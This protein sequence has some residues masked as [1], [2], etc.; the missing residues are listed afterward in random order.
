[1]CCSCW[2]QSACR[3]LQVVY[4]EEP[5]WSVLIKKAASEG[6]VS[7]PDFM[8]ALQKRME[9]TVLG[10]QSGSYAQ[11]VQ[12]GASEHLGGSEPCP[13]S[14]VCT[15]TSLGVCTARAERCKR[16]LSLLL[17]NKPASAA[18]TCSTSLGD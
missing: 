6:S 15:R 7:E 16:H 12:V 11:R 17:S 18:N 8:E 9:T 2:L 14:A 3:R 1:M 10:L 5:E 4:A 13:T